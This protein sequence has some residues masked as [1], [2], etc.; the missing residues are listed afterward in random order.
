MNEEIKEVINMLKN[1][2]PN[3]LQMA[4]ESEDKEYKHSYAIGVLESNIPYY[5]RKLEVLLNAESKTD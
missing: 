1:A 4:E 5:A 3:A 2:V